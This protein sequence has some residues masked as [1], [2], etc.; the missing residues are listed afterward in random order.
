MEEDLMLSVVVVVENN[1]NSIHPNGKHE[2]FEQ[3][4]LNFPD[5]VLTRY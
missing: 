5:L 2:A 4:Q 3:I 1:C